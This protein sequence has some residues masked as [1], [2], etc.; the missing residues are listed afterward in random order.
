MEKTVNQI[1]HTLVNRRWRNSLK[2]V[3]MYRGADVGS[4]H[5]LVVTIIP[6]SPAVLKQQKKQLKYNTANLLN[7]D[8]LASF[9]AT[10]GGIFHALAELE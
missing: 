2:D 1:D 5:N 9:D 8:I 7:R 3:R 4:D 10:I 6:F